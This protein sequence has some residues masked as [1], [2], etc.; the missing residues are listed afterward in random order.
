MSSSWGNK[1]RHEPKKTLWGAVQSRG[2]LV[3][4]VTH[5]P[6]RWTVPQRLLEEDMAISDLV[7]TRCPNCLKYWQKSEEFERLT[8]QES[9]KYILGVLGEPILIPCITWTVKCSFCHV[10]SEIPIADL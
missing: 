8:T 2:G 6:F 10:S 4:P 7:G 5:H 9:L 1:I 3:T